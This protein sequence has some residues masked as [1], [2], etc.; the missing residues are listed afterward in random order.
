MRCL[1]ATLVLAGLI[2]LVAAISPAVAHRRANLPAPAD[3]VLEG[4]AIYTVDPARSIAEALA[5]RDGRLVFV[6]TRSAAQ[7]WIGPRTRVEELSGRMVLP[8]LVDAHLHPLDIV[9]VDVCDLNSRALALAELSAFVAGCVARYNLRRAAGW[10]CISGTIPPAI[11]PTP[12]IRHCVPLWMRL[13][14]RCRSSCWA[15]TLI[16]A[17]STAGAVAGKKCEGRDHRPDK[18]DACGGVCRIQAVR[19]CG[20]HRRTERRRKRGCPLPNQC[21]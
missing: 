17:R 20:R 9:D 18:G 4:G 8:G 10:S 5:V 3:L 7:R 13:R 21:K 1:S 12:A 14:P 16:T 11:S 2:T 6:G 15:M 19:R